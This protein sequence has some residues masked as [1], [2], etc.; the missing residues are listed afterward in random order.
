MTGPFDSERESQDTQADLDADALMALY[1]PCEECGAPRDV[2]TTQHDLEQCRSWSARFTLTAMRTG[3]DGHPAV[4]GFRQ[5]RRKHAARQ[6]G[7]GQ[8]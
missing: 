3:S 1:G 7:W 8:R 6:H 4:Q 5:T 2:R